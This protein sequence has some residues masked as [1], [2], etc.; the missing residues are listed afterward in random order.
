MNSTIA[1][2]ATTPLTDIDLRNNSPYHVLNSTR[3]V[4][5]FIMHGSSWSDDLVPYVKATDGMNTKLSSTG[6]LINT[7]TNANTAPPTNYT[8]YPQKHLIKTFP[9]VNH[10]L[11]HYSASQE[12]TTFSIVRSNTMDWLNGHK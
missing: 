1:K 9:N 12:D 7:I 8:S 3:V 11:V 10:G 6:G 2:N 4:P 5:T